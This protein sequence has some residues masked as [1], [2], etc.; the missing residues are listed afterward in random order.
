MVMFCITS[1]HDMPAIINGGSP[2]HTIHIL[3]FTLYWNFIPYI[4]ASIL[5]RRT[6]SSEQFSLSIPFSSSHLTSIM[7]STN[8]DYT[9]KPGNPGPWNTGLCD[10]CSDVKTCCLTMWCPCVT[11]GQIAEIVDRGNTSCFVAATLYAIVG[12]SKW[13]F[14]LSCFYRTKMR[15]QFMLEKSPCDDCLV[16]WFCE[17]CALCQ[18]HRELKIRGFNPSIGWHANMD[19]QQGVEVAPKVEEGMNR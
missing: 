16:H 7:S 15:K 8:L 19:N 9:G 4:Y 2:T 5:I 12:L 11:F 14:C 13:G 17:P 6:A 1:L 18:E 10:C 3:A